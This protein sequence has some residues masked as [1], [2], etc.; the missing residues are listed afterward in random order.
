[1]DA[2]GFHQKRSAVPSLTRLQPRA[3]KQP[4]AL[5]NFM[6]NHWPKR[7]VDKIIERLVGLI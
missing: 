7:I 1:M 5:Q 3:P 4:D 2:K 6:V